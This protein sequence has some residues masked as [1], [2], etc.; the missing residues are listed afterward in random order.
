MPLM[1]MPLESYCGQ[2]KKLYGH[3]VDAG[4]T[5]FRNGRGGNF[6]GAM[7][8]P[9]VACADKPG[10]RFRGTE[11]LGHSAVVSDRARSSFRISES[12]SVAGQFA[13]CRLPS[14]RIRLREYGSSGTGFILDPGA[15]SPVFARWAWASLFPFRHMGGL[16][17]NSN[18]N[19]KDENESGK[20]SQFRSLIDPIPT[21]WRHILVAK[22][23]AVEFSDTPM[24]HWAGSERIAA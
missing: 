16:S 2:G 3:S 10:F 7:T 21:Y 6:E 23:R 9:R 14:A 19:D 4:R 20:S 24:G 8:I 18:P 12:F 5:M 11:T 15:D 13:L 17:E 1:H 22:L